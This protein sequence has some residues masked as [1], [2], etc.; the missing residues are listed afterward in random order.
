LDL[1]G[2]MP[3]DTRQFQAVFRELCSVPAEPDGLV[4]HAD[5]VHAR[6]IREQHEYQGIRVTM[7]ATLKRIRKPRDVTRISGV[8]GASARKARVTSCQVAGCS[9]GEALRV[10]GILGDTV[11]DFLS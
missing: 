9:A 6:A 4:F 5:S 2:F 11:N 8:S 10:H 7:L 1:L 3:P